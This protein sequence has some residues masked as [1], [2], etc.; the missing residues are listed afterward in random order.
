MVA[1]TT[2]RRIKKMNREK[3]IRDEED[4][5]EELLVGEIMKL[6]SERLFN[7]ERSDKFDE[8]CEPLVMDF[9]ETIVESIDAESE[10]EEDE[11]DEEEEEEEQE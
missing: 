7:G 9:V 1:L 8:F 4:Q 5:R 11:E 3:A 6:I 10:E 2:K